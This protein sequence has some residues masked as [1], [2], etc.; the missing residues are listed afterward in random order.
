MHLRQYIIGHKHLQE[1]KI[2]TIERSK[3]YDALEIF[4][5]A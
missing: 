4:K 3:I 5:M 2:M 1:K